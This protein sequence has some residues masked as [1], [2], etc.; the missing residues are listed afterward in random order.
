VNGIEGI[1]A[2]G[3]SGQAFINPILLFFAL[4]TQ[5]AMV[6]AFLAPTPF[7]FFALC[8]RIAVFSA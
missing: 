7:I 8:Q 4:W 6:C 5:D 2:F 1:F 3:W